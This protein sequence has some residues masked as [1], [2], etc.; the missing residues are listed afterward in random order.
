MIKREWVLWILMAIVLMPVIRFVQ[1]LQDV[2][3]ISDPVSV[4]LQVA[5]LLL[6]VGAFV[7]TVV[8]HI[9]LLRRVRALGG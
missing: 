4:L 7:V 6:Y 9:V 1:M 8:S 5:L 3:A 2:V